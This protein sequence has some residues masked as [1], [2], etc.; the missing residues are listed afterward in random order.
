M[1]KSSAALLVVT[2]LVSGCVVTTETAVHSFNGNSVEVELYG[3]TFAYGSDE[4][5]A[6]QIA[7]AKGQAEEVCGSSA[8]FLSRRMDAQPQNGI[9]YVPSKNIA[10]FKCR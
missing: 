7:A 9:Y 1:K 5:K 10:L 6:A 4:E 8:Q 2:A 3:D